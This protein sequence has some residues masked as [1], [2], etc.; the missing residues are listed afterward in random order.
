[1]SSGDGADT[2]T[3]SLRVLNAELSVRGVDGRIAR[4]IVRLGRDRFGVEAVS[5]RLRAPG[6]GPSNGAKAAKHPA[7][8]HPDSPATSPVVVHVALSTDLH[9]DLAVATA[10]RRAALVELLRA[11]ADATAEG[12]HLVVV[13]S[14][15]V[16]GARATNP[17]P[18]PPEAP[19]HAR[20][21]GGLTGDLLVVEA[22]LEAV[23]RA[24]PDLRVSVVRAAAVVGP[25]IDTTISR[26]FESPRLLVLSGSSPRWQFVHVEDLAA[27]VMCVV[28]HGPDGGLGPVV[29]VGAPGSISQA[30]VELVSGKRRLELPA[31]VALATAR[32]LH[33]AGVL[34]TSGVDLDYVRYPWLVSAEPL[35]AVGW[36]AVHDNET[37]LQVMLDGIRRD[38]GLLA[39]RR[40]AAVGTASAA[41]AVVGTAAIVRRRKR[42]GSLI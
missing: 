8:S 33:A 41:V 26:H 7:G 5:T 6:L 42:R 21:D 3:I 32:R 35:E 13:S 31:A 20:D 27:A 22:E 40:D 14:A 16:Y 11:S 28:G 34:N 9:R 30:R 36:R 24:R 4:E 1:M 23:R 2:G 15:R 39:L 10:V 19:L 17:V 38:R 12:G 18:I 37:C 29:T 25:G